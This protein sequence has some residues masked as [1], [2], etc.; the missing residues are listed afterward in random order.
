MDDGVAALQML[1]FQL[2]I[3]LLLCNVGSTKGDTGVIFIKV[4]EKKITWGHGGDQQD[5]CSRECQHDYHVN[6]MDQKSYKFTE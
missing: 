3:C 2:I 4:K 6:A 1:L 5:H